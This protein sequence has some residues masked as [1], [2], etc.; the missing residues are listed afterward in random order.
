MDFVLSTDDFQISKDKRK[1]TLFTID[2]RLRSEAL[3]NSV[4]STK[5]ILGA[6]VND[7]YKSINFNASSVKSFSKY[8]GDLYRRRGTKNMSYDD[9]LRLISCLSNQ[10]RYLIVNESKTFYLYDPAN[11]IVINDS[12]FMYLSVEHL[13]NIRENSIQVDRPFSCL[14]FFSPEMIRITSIP[15]EINYKI[16]YYSLGAWIIYALFNVNI[17]N[18]DTTLID[19]DNIMGPIC[20]TKVYWFILRCLDSDVERREL[21]YI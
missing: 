2:F 3:I 19:L 8:Q 18:S 20:G 16:I 21:L 14:G 9:A 12:K 10:I 4:I 6:T 11:I 15:S 1:N 17:T 13:M 5:Q 7:D